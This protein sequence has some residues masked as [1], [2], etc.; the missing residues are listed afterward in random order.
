VKSLR[1]PLAAVLLAL[2]WPA[3]AQSKKILILGDSHFAGP[4][5]YG[6]W[7]DAQKSR[8]I[9]GVDGGL[10]AKF[11]DQIASYAVCSAST[12]WWVNKARPNLNVCWNAR[13]FGAAVQEAQTG[14]RP[15]GMPDIDDLMKTP[16]D[17]VIIALGSNPDGGS[18]DNTITAGMLML[19]KIPKNSQCFWIG[20]PPMPGSANRVEEFY[21][22]FPQIVSLGGRSCTLIDSRNFVNASQSTKD[23]YY[24]QPAIN[25]ANGVL[26]VLAP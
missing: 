21:R 16:W 1:S 8:R 19:T 23:H 26:G 13:E 15:G 5:G 11:G 9:E 3:S 10:R 7:A 22:V 4:M 20:P 17:M 14:N 2:A 18:S 6:Y 24:G 12:H 25:W